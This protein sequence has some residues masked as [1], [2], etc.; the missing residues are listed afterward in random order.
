MRHAGS[1]STKEGCA[2]IYYAMLLF[3]VLFWGVSSVLYTY[4]YNRYSASALGALLAL[5]SF[6]LFL[7][8]AVK[9]RLRFD[10]RYARIALPICLL[11]GLAC[12]LQRIGLQYTTPASY[13][14][15]EHLSCVVVPIMMF[16][17]IRKRPTLL[18][19]LAGCVCLVGCFVLSGLSV[20]GLSFGM[21]DALC[22]AAGILLG[23][24]M[25]SLCSV[26][27]YS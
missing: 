5:S 16:L 2:W 25:A 21:G 27:F 23:V 7:A 11:N 22:A 17:F 9:K 4:I 18:Q 8:L 24:V 12:L 14:F 3:V 1:G 10:R 13:A 26:H 19:G 6:L 20:D 15:L